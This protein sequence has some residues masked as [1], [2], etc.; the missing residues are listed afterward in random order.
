[1]IEYKVHDETSYMLTK[2]G[3]TFAKDGSPEARVWAAL[4]EGGNEGKS[5]A[6]LKV[7]DAEIFYRSELMPNQFYSR[8]LW[9]LIY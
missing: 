3:N 5:M 4:P 7:C 1:M 6:D 2:E 8:L 9:A